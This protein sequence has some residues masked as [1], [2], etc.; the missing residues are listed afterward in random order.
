MKRPTSEFP[1]KTSAFESALVILKLIDS[2]ENETGAAVTRFRVS[3]KTL[4]RL[5]SRKRIPPDYLQE[6]QEWLFDAG[7]ALV[8]AGTTFA[9]IKISTV[10]KW[11]RLASKRIE[12][13]LAEI[14]SGTFDFGSLMHLMK[15]APNRDDEEDA[16][17]GD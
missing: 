9:M 1:N 14:A 10:E 6:V 8:F 3:E 7:W 2:K 17:G 16:T 13:E 12:N 5:F 15:R 4:K 11:A